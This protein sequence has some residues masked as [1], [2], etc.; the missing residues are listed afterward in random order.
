M[1][2]IM[3][4]NIFRPLFVVFLLHSAF[5]LKAQECTRTLL[6]KT[7]MAVESGEVVCTPGNIGTISISSL[8]INGG[9]TLIVKSG[10]I[11]MVGSAATING[12]MIIESSAG[13]NI[14]SSITMGW[15]GNGGTH[16]AVIKLK[17]RSFVALGGSFNIHKPGAG[18]AYI[19]TEG[20]TVIE[21]CGPFTQSIG[22]TFIRYVGRDHLTSYFITRA[23]AKGQNEVSKI[24]DSDRVNWIALNSI[25]HQDR[26]EANLC[27]PNA[28]YKTCPEMWPPGAGDW[29]KPGQ[30]K[31]MWDQCGN[32]LDIFDELPGGNFWMGGTPGKINDWN[33]DTNWTA[34]FV[35]AD[36]SDVEFATEENYGEFAVADLHVPS[37]KVYNVKNLIN[38]SYKAL[39]VPPASIIVINEEVIGSETMSLAGKLIIKAAPGQPNGSFLAPAMCDKDVFAEVELYAYGR[40]LTEEE[41][42]K[43]KWWTDDISGS[44]TETVSLYSEHTWQYVGIPVADLE[45]YPTFYEAWMKKYYETRNGSIYGD[46]GIPTFYDKWEYVKSSDKLD[47]FAGYGLTQDVPKHYYMR[48]KLCFCDKELTLTRRAAKVDGASGINEHYGLGQN[49]FGNSY[50][51]AINVKEGIVFDN[52]VEGDE[53]SLVEKTVYLYRTGSF[54]DWGKDGVIITEDTAP[55]A[56]SYIAIPTELSSEVWDNQIPS[57][58]GFLLRFTDEATEYGEPDRRVKLTYKGG[59]LV[60]NTRPQLTA[61]P[62]KSYLTVSLLSKTTHDKVW[63]FSQEGTSDKFDNGWDGYKYFGTPTAFIYSESPIGPLQVNTSSS[64]NGKILTL[65]PNEDTEYSLVFSKSNLDDHGDLKLLDLVTQKIIPLTNKRTEYHFTANHAGKA[66]KRFMLINGDES[67]LDN[68]Y[69]LDAYILS[70]NELVLMNRTAENGSYVLY[71]LAGKAIMRDTLYAGFSQQSL[72]LQNGVYILNLEADGQHKGVKLIIK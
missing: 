34:G 42:V 72:S 63:L 71:D 39:V 55:N 19:E 22:N 51:A 46:K 35:P 8:T 40:K 12:T 29:V 45:A 59:G 66:I 65:Q 68:P 32:I 38:E 23:Q 1:N 10:D 58:Q 4:N 36:D 61:A 26:G 33:E 31:P 2:L 70:N 25:T 50:T 16:D 17:E 30:S 43:E 18:T 54:Q 44:P 11:L 52:V 64:L 7:G 28:D 5:F 37:D 41:L 27:G 53:E 24:A 9:G 60:G 47:R 21:V 57:L 13:V 3:K 14:G 62:K 6:A 56:G 20:S 69:N 15:T 48:G 49:L 67:A